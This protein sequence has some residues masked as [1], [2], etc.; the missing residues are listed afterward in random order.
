MSELVA[1]GLSVAKSGQRLLIDA[2]I[3]LKQGELVALVGPNGAGKT[4]LLR[5][6]LGLER[7]TGRVLLDRTPLTELSSIERAREIAYLPQQRQLAWPNRVRDIVTLGRFAHGTTL[8]KLGPQDKEVVD[9]A[10]RACDLEIYANRQA[11]TLSGGELGRVHC[12]RAFA[13]QSRFILA[14]EPVAALDPL[15]QHRI[16]ALFRD[17]V[18][19]GGGALIVL[20]DIALALQFADRFVWMKQGHL[21]PDEQAPQTVTAE[22]LADVYGMAAEVSDQNIIWKTPI[23][24]K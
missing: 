17:Y 7:T 9:D 1:S 13:S 15:H 18:D 20:H 23:A 11:N 24:G 21:L 5:S 3:T 10:L 12:A 14:D 2:D 22:R 16:M 6:I 4:T 8:G 19:S